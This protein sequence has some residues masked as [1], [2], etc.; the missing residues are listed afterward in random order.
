MFVGGG[1]TDGRYFKVYD[2]PVLGV[3]PHERLVFSVDL[4]EYKDRQDFDERVF[5]EVELLAKTE[6]E[7]GAGLQRRVTLEALRELLTAEGSRVGAAGLTVAIADDPSES[8]RAD[9]AQRP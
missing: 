9:G 6:L 1:V 4:T 8:R 2:A 5:P 7:T 3:L